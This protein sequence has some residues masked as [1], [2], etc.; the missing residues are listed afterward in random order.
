MVHAAWLWAGVFILAQVGNALAAQEPSRTWRDAAGKFS[1]DAVLIDVQGDSVRLL[2][3]DGATIQVPLAKLSE[4]DREYVKNRAAPQS[5]ADNPFATPSLDKAEPVRAA[6]S[7]QTITPSQDVGDLPGEGGTIV[8]LPKSTECEPLTADPAAPLPNLKAGQVLVAPADA[9]DDPSSLV[10]LNSRQA[11]FAISLGRS[12]AGSQ[13]PPTGKVFVGQLPKGP[14]TQVIEIN[15]SNKLLHHHEATGQSLLI[16]NLDI[17]KRGGDLVVMKGLADGKPVE[18]Y[19]R[20]LPG[21]E[22]PGFKPQVTQAQLIAE[23]LAL[24]VVDSVLYCWNLK[25]STLLYRTEGNTVTGAAGVTLSGSGKWLAIPQQDGFTLLESATGEDRGYVQTGTSTQPG[26]AFHPDG[27]HI[28]YCSS[29][30]WGVWDIVEAKIQVSGIVTEHLGDKLTGWVSN[31]WFLTELGNVIDTKS[32]MLVW[33]YYT[34]AVEAKKIWSNWLAVASK[35]NGIKITTLPIPDPKALAAVR[36]LEQQKNLMVTAPGAEVRIEVE[37]TEAVNKMELVAALTTAIE[38]AGWKISSSAK[39]T[40]V[41]KIGRGK[42]YQL[43]YTSNPVGA[44]SAAGQTYTVDIKPFT[45]NLEIRSGKNI[46]WT[47]NTENHVPPF[48]ILR[49]DE[50]V[51]QAVKKYERPQSEFF[52]SLQIPPRIPKSELAKGLGGSRIDKGVWVDFPR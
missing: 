20:R 35:D 34:G 49:E 29:N 36:R 25:S 3:K 40:V 27:R 1:I 51:E 23:D 11:L 13:V 10:T 47:R 41:A 24:V 43:Q 6:F 44:A 5:D 52:S 26:V 37:S 17:L 19:R 32:Q 30:M 48:L 33:S 50:T 9:Y 2:K 22:K 45:A 39:L 38:R 15:E 42:P 16:S 7:L 28:A 8:L 31:D 12:V 18:V 14:F 46:L 4:V 21:H